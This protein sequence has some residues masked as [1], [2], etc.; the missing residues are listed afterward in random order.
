MVGGVD[1]KHSGSQMEMHI[2]DWKAS[3][4]QRKFQLHTVSKAKQW[5]LFL[6]NQPQLT[7]S[8]LRLID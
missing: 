3:C 5:G 1:T 8:Q 4:D 7:L 6:V 2:A